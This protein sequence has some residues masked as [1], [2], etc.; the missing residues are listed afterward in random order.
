MERRSVYNLVPPFLLNDRSIVG[1]LRPTSQVET[2]ED[3]LTAVVRAKNST[4][5]SLLDGSVNRFLSLEI[6][7]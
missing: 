4:M 2:E 6:Q 3:L 7:T 5:L 1:G